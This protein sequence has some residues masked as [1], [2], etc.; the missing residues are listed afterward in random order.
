MKFL[1]GAKLM[2]NKII[3][4]MITVVIVLCLSGKRK[5]FEGSKDNTKRTG[6][7]T[8]PTMMPDLY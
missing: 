2:R 7:R 1:K 3:A 5:T 8:Q 4:L 6:G